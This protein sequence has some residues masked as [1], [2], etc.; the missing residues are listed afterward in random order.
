MK[1]AGHISAIK[2]PLSGI[3]L[4]LVGFLFVDDID[5]VAMSTKFDAVIVV[6]DRPKQMIDF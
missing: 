4:L 5:L 3:V 6:H 1:E 2:F